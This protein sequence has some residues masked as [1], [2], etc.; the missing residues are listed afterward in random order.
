MTYQLLSAPT[1][2]FDV[3]VTGQQ[4]QVSAKS[5]VPR[6]RLEPPSSKSTTAAQTPCR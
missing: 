4:M 1:D 2:Q 3:T 6:G 5:G